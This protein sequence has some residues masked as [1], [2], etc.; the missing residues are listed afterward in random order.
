VR[1][2]GQAQGLLLFCHKQP[3]QMQPSRR[4]TVRI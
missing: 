2:Q 3:G 4:Q 1:G